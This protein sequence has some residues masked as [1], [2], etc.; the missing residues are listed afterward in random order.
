[1]CSPTKIMIPNGSHCHR[2][3]GFI[4]GS[5]YALSCRI[6][7]MEFVISEECIHV[8]IQIQKGFQG[9]YTTGSS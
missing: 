9:G 8:A 4:E 2:E 5:I 6:L 7:T 3:T 1:M